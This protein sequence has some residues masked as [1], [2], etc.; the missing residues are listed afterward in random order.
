MRDF[1]KVL[2]QGQSGMGKSY[3]AKNLD[4]KTTGYINVENQPLPFK[5]NFT[6]FVRPTTANEAMTNLVKFANDP[7]IKVI[8]F[9]SFS[10]YMDLVLKEARATKRGFDVWSEYNTKIAEFH[11]VLNKIKKE[12]FVTG[13]YE[14]LGIEGSEEKRLKVHGKTLCRA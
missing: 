10:A 6:N 5:N 4:P 1:Y 2:I 12:V 3:M 14:I 13:H 8:Y 9:D 7:E 11:E